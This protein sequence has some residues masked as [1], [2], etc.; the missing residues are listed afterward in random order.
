MQRRHFLTTLAAASVAPSVSWAEAGDAR[1]LSA[2]QNADGSYA[3]YG[4]NAAL[5]IAFAHP[6][7]ARGHSGAAHPHRAEAVMFAR[8]PG[9]FAYVLDCATGV[10][11]NHLAPPEGRHFYG[12]GAFTAD[13]TMLL[14][15]ESEYATGAGRIGLWD[16]AAG[17]VRT[18]EIS[19]GGVGPHEIIRRST[20][21]FAI[22]NG[23]IR[24][25]PDT[26]REKLNL[27]TMQ[28]NL[29]LLA[30]DLTAL[31]RVTLGPQDRLNSIRH[32]AEG[33]QA[34]VAIGMQWNGDLSIH[35]QPVAIVTASG[36][37][38]RPTVPDGLIARIQGYIGSIAADA[39]SIVASAPRGS[40]ALTF[41]NDAMSG[42]IPAQDA[43][44]LASGSQGIV[45][46]QGT[47][48]ITVPGTSQ[49]QD[50]P[51]AWDNH[52]VAV[53]A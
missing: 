31:S 46:S 13:G 18:G 7:P 52:M 39:D 12:H 43:C 49:A 5:D 29:T 14:T 48:R 6:L 41:H 36:D 10:I 15:T 38:I 47:G 2:A 19:S 17:Y 28:P 40:C 37:I 27:D 30:E 26:G 23:G 11:L 3:L 51:V 9:R 16:V 35:R 20:G 45:L 33:P 53:H 8:R 50:H 25:H 34:S 44:G 1:F 21:G 32:I 24:T 22:A 4:L 42:V